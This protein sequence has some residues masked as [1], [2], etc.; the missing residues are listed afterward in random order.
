[1]M[2]SV[3][4]NWQ[5]WHLKWLFHWCSGDRWWFRWQC[6]WKNWAKP[7]KTQGLDAAP[8]DVQICCWGPNQGWLRP[9]VDLQRWQTGQSN[10]PGFGRHWKLL[11]ATQ[12]THT[13]MCVCVCVIRTFSNTLVL[14]YSYNM[15]LTLFAG[16]SWFQTF[17][18]FQKQHVIFLSLF[19]LY[20]AGGKPLPWH[21]ALAFQRRKQR[22]PIMTWCRGKGWWPVA[23]SG[24]A[25]GILILMV[26]NCWWTGLIEFF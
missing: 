22:P 4:H 21:P 26:K 16:D 19:V 25:L 10:L 20:F 6:E 3:W 13:H 24:C 2:I 15:F 5:K 18:T 7:S 12:H 8:E 9:S 11:M 1:M 23:F 17:Q 14:I